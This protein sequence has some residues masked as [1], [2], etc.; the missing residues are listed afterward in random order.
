M[1]T[2]YF[3]VDVGELSP[4]VATE[5]KALREVVDNANKSVQKRSDELLSSVIN[6][7]V[8]FG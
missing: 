8:G 6:K 7:A 3:N 2:S 5:I 1:I 4:E